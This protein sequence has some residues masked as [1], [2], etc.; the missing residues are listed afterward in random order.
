[1]S[2]MI[3]LKKLGDVCHFVRGP[4]GGSLK[5]S[6]FKDEGNAVYEQQHAI[7][8]QFSE[9]RYYVDDNK[10]EEM[11]RFELL[12]GDLIMSCSGT[13]GKVAIV[14]E[15]I[16]IGIINQALLKLTT[17]TQLD[18]EYLR[19]WMISDDFQD[20][21]AKHTVGAAIKN[22]ASVKVLKQ[23]EIPL[24]PL[25]EQQRI[26]AILD[27][28]FT[29]IATAKENAQQNLLNAKELFESYLQNV[30]ENK[31]DVWEKKRLDEVCKITS[32]LIDPKESQYKDLI[33]I[34][35]G[36]IVSEKGTL[37]DLKTAK[38]ENLISGKFLFDESMVL[39]SKIRPY[40]KKIV[41]C[42][43]KGL[44]SADIYPLVPYKD[45][46][47]QSFLYHLLSSNHFTEYAIEGSQ[48]AGMP[49]VNRKHLFEY[50]FSLPPIKEQQQIV[51]K[52]NSLS[53]ETK[54]LEGIYQQKINDLEELKKSVLEKAFKGELKMV[55]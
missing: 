2:E 44:C 31:G 4:F 26:V 34:G 47:I 13:M 36:N 27:K 9:I 14:P 18:V 51:K 55:N 10:F 43:F 53:A 8:N 48:R 15:N 1:M 19:Y 3:S 35:A 40:L 46:M 33:H 17:S 25:P 12:T 11:K 45:K 24:P 49:K 29:S 39:Y 7:Y 42:E 32:K 37:I 20:S 6:C 21:L 16:K 30:F 23:I 54:K 52:L 28:A 5:K 50:S 22:V 41:K 38:E